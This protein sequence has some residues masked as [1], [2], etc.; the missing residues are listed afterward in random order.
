MGLQRLSLIQPLLELIMKGASAVL[1]WQLR[2][3]YTA[4]VPLFLF[5][6]VGSL[7]QLCTFA[8]AQLHL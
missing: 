2:V 1:V 8:T 7:L 6:C 4:P 5:P 3:Y